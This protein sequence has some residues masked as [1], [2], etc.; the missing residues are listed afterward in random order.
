MQTV[1]I[2][3]ADATDSSSLARM[4]AGTDVIISTAGP[5]AKYGSS[6]VAAAVEQGSNYCDITGGWFC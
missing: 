4:A 6:V 3:I 2:V 1:P 5:F